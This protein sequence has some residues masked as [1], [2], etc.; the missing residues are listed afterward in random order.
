MHVNIQHGKENW[1][2]QQVLKYFSSM[3]W[4]KLFTM[5]CILQIYF[6]DPNTSKGCVG[7]RGWCEEDGDMTVKEGVTERDGSWTREDKALEK[8]IL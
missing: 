2:K 7:G 6:I 4:L 1:T 3:Y 5:H 8:R